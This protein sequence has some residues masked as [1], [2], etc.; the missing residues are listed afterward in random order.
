MELRTSWYFNFP[1]LVVE[2]TLAEL[3][4]VV[5]KKPN[6]RKGPVPTFWRLNSGRSATGANSGRV[7]W[8][9]QGGLGYKPSDHF[10]DTS[11]VATPGCWRLGYK[12][13]DHFRTQVAATPHY[14]ARLRVVQ[15]K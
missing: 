3:A 11:Q 2:L 10:W 5:K 9:G 12:P 7:G 14:R 1:F 6:K 4:G 13:S 8:V 15:A